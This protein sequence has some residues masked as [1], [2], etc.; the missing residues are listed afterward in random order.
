MKNWC[1]EDNAGDPYN[2]P[3]KVQYGGDHY[4]KRTIQPI[5]FILANELDFCEGNV[6][7]YVTRWKDK[8]G[9]EDLEKARH[10]LE[11]LIENVKKGGK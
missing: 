3:L 2:D 1:V 11:F 6:V 4:H 8:N 7:K 10:Y 5:E 9:L